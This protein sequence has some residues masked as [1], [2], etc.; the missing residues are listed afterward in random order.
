MVFLTITAVQNACINTK[1]VC[2]IVNPAGIIFTST[3]RRKTNFPCLPIRR[4]LRTPLQQIGTRNF[5]LMK[6]YKLGLFDQVEK[7]YC[8]SV[9][10]LFLLLLLLLFLTDFGN[11][12]EE[13]GKV[14]KIK[15]YLALLHLSKTPMVKLFSFRGRHFRSRKEKTSNLDGTLYLP[16]KTIEIFETWKRCSS[17]LDL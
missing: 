14:F 15:T 10:L 11:R 16:Y 17:R 8:Y 3:A 6:N 12:F 9:V 2:W 7:T 4:Y 5:I 1:D 13:N